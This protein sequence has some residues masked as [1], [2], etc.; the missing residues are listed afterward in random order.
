MVGD[1]T[2]QAKNDARKAAST[3]ITEILRENAEQLGV[4]PDSVKAT[5]TIAYDI[6]RDVQVIRFEIVADAA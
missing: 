4:N 6:D 1:V 2:S 3:R 5:A